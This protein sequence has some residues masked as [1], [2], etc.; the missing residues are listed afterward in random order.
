MS[1][2]DEKRAANRQRILDAATDLFFENTF[3][4]TTVDMICERLKVTKPFVYWYFADKSDILDTLSLAAA[5]ATLGVL[6]EHLSGEERIAERLRSGL[7]DF[8][9][10]YIR[11]FKAGTFYYREPAAH[12]IETRERI[13]SMASE[14]H[15][16]LTALLQTGIDVGVLPRQDAKMTAFAIGGIVGFMHT[17]YKDDGPLPPEVVAERLTETMLR[18]AGLQPDVA[19]SRSPSARA[20]RSR[21]LPLRAEIDREG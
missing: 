4:G 16:D 19:K 21:I 2:R 3:A 14:F 12:S 8:A 6:K 5:K 13:R 11:H 18:A 15:R 20:A 10:S 7:Q 1:R 9:N 17:W